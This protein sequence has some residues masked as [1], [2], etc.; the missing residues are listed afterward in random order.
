LR[1]AVIR[2]EYAKKAK[3]SPCPANPHIFKLHIFGKMSSPKI[4]F[5]PILFKNS[6]IFFRPVNGFRSRKAGERTF[7]ATS[8]FAETTYPKVLFYIFSRRPSAAKAR[9]PNNFLFPKQFR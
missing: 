9:I 8:G 2:P 7:C 3:I 4:R 5:Y 1:T 6:W